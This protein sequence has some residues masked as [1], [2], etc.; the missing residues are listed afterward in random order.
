M[1]KIFFSTQAQHSYEAQIS[2][3]RSTISNL[4]SDLE[5]MRTDRLSL[6]EDVHA[7]RDMN[8]KLDASKEQIGRQLAAKNLEI[9]QVCCGGGT[10]TSW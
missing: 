1:L 5:R 6:Q 2:S 8:A 9:E 7:A 3:L 10:A 4:E